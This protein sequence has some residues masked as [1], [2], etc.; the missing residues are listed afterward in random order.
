M[1]ASPAS[2]ASRTLNARR[3]SAG[4][5]SCRRP[6][7]PLPSSSKDIIMEKVM[8][9]TIVKEYDGEGLRMLSINEMIRRELPT[10]PVYDEKERDKLSTAIL[11]DLCRRVKMLIPGQDHHTTLDRDRR[12]TPKRN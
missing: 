7:E 8:L 6:P 1:F 12:N 10:K 2:P 5:R 9:T 11:K 4:T 3:S